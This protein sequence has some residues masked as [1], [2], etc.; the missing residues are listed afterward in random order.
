MER[1]YGIIANKSYNKDA[2]RGAEVDDKDWQAD[3]YEATGI[4]IPDEYLYTPKG[5]RFFMK[6][7]RKK[8]I[9]DLQERFGM[10]E[11]EAMMK[12]EPMYKTAMQGY[13]K[14]LKGK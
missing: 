11:K 14:L 6:E 10:T 9:N 8:N 1:R 3:V 5:P 7:A 2:L 12:A 13:D 4:M